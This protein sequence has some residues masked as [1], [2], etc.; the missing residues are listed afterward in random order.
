MPKND[1]G[2][3]QLDLEEIRNVRV[4]S[5]RFEYSSRK[6]FPFWNQ[7][8]LSPLFGAFLKFLLN[9]LRFL[10]NNLKNFTSKKDAQYPGF[11]LQSGTIFS[12]ASHFRPLLGIFKNWFLQISCVF[13]RRTFCNSVT[14]HRTELLLSFLERGRS[15]VSFDI[16]CTPRFRLLPALLPYWAQKTKKVEKTTV[17]M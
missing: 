7:S 16:K 5:G 15:D 12:S 10:T 8:T 6:C 17:F 13:H 4:F 2:L 14:F 11:I 1:N 9:K 3:R